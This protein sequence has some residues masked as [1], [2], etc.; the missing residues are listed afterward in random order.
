VG[1]KT[2]MLAYV[3]GRAPDILKSDPQLDRA[4]T[5]T[6]AARLFPDEKLEPFGDGN[7]SYTYP[8]DNEVHI[9]YFPGLTVIAAKEFAIDYP[10][11]LPSRFVEA[12]VVEI[13]VSITRPGETRPHASAARRVS[14][15]DGT[16]S[17]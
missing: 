17:A 4:A 8:P 13:L 12:V 9:G 16:A 14:G 2:W 15:A 1:A 7:L 6:M 11:R 10:S 5:V 3:D